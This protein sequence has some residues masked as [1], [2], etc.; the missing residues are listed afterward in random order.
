MKKDRKLK[1]NQKNSIK[2]I[3]NLR[4]KRIILLLRKHSIILNLKE[5]K[6]K[7]KNKQ[8]KKTL[9]LI[10][11]QY[12]RLTNRSFFKELLRI[13]KI[14]KWTLRNKLINK[15]DSTTL[16]LRI[17]SLLRIPLTYLLL[18]HSQFNSL[19]VF[20]LKERL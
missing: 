14:L 12:S 3:W 10:F 19:V 18:L 5:E 1:H 2:S 15:G 9:S 4:P 13:Q 6:N 7:K 20:Q 8:V 16:L 11:Y 17:A